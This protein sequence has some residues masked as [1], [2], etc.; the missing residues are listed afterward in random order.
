M[1]ISDRRLANLDGPTNYKEAM[2]GH[3]VAQWKEA[4]DN[5]IHSMTDNQVWNLVD[6][7][8]GLRV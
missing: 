6:P 2:E 4:M 7:M 3:E 5:E 1:F 8:I